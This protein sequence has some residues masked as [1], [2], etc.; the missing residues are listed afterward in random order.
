MG[1]DRK[2][3]FT[4]WCLILQT[5]KAKDPGCGPKDGKSLFSGLAAGESSWSQHRQRRLQDHG[6]ERK[7]LLSTTLQVRLVLSVPRMPACPW[8]GCGTWWGGAGPA[9][10]PRAFC[11]AV[12]CVFAK[13][14]L[15]A[16]ASVVRSLPDSSVALLCDAAF[17]NEGP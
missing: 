6:K 14:G 7:E 17:S 3:L 2:R 16:C 11:S 12:E 8:E 9:F 4:V 1:T 10:I 15:V 5:A 13:L